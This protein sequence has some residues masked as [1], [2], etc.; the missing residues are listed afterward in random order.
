VTR[1]PACARPGAAGVGRPPPSTRASTS[2]A[3][4]PVPAT[5]AGTAEAGRT[6]PPGGA[7]S[8]A[9]ATRLTPAGAAAAGRRR[10]RGRRPRPRWPR[11]TPRRAPGRPP[12]GA[13]LAGRRGHLRGHGRGQVLGDRRAPGHG[14][15]VGARERVPVG[16]GHPPRDGV[17][18]GRQAVGQPLD[19]GGVAQL[20]LALRHDRS[21]RSGHDDLG[22]QRLGGGAEL[23]LHLVRRGGQRRVRRRDRGDQLVVRLRGR[24]PGAQEDEGEGGGSGHHRQH[25]WSARRG[26]SSWWGRPASRHDGGSYAGAV[27]VARALGGERWTAGPGGPSTPRRCSSGRGRSTIVVPGECTGPGSGA[28]GPPRWCGGR[29]A[30]DGWGSRPRWLLPASRPRRLVNDRRGPQRRH[31]P[32]TD[33]LVLCC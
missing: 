10:P 27:P 21:V 18:P 33:A 26:A 8:T 19:H 30:D 28:E 6:S 20:G 5:T 12:P 22:A 17:G 9:N 15:G 13:R 4:S 16:G 11:A 32:G 25:A 7:G 29:R 2:T 24:R 23:Q 3:T 14:E 31:P 1:G